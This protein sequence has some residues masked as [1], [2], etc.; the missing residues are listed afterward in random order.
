[1]LNVKLVINKWEMIAVSEIPWLCPEGA[2]MQSEEKE[3]VVW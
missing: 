2:T 3:N 1:M